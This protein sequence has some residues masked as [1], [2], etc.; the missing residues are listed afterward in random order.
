MTHWSRRFQN[1]HRVLLSF[2]P[3]TTENNP[4]IGG[5]PESWSEAESV[6]VEQSGKKPTDNMCH[7]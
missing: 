7:V 1:H 3:Y 5:Y 2:F 6:Q 4:Q